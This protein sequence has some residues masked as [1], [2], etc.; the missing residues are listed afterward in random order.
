MKEIAPFLIG[1]AGGSCS[2]KSSVTV[3]ISKRHTN[4]TLI[5]FD[6][7]IYS[8]DII[9]YTHVIDWETPDLYDLEKLKGDLI[10]LKR[11]D[12]AALSLSS[13]ESPDQNILVD[14]IQPQSLII[15]EGFLLFHDPNIRD[16]LNLMVFLDLSEEE[17]IGRRLARKT[18]A[19]P[20]D[21]EEYLK[22]LLLKGH[23][24]YVLPTKIYANHIIDASKP[25]TQVSDEVDKLI[26]TYISK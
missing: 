9:D 18:R 23:K 15:I 2:G 10:K 12:I 21:E 8:R 14:I 25:I 5:H 4:S 17:M 11:G 3:E 16:Q 6:D 19:A 7:Y 24:K 22:T 1:I 20:W 26:S 13:K